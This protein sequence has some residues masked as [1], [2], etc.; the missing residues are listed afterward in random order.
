MSK[1]LQALKNLSSRT[2]PSETKEK[3][4][5][6]AAREAAA[7]VAVAPVAA[8]PAAAAADPVLPPLNR[9]QRMKQVLARHLAAPTP[10]E[11]IRRPTTEDEPQ[12]ATDFPSLQPT[13]AAA[14][15]MTVPM[16]A[17]LVELRRAAELPRLD[18]PLEPPTK[19]EPA[20]PAPSPI[21]AT[22]S[23]E[24][25]SPP[26][27]REALPVGIA[28]LEAVT[29]LVSKL[30][31]VGGARSEVGDTR[32]E[33]RGQRA[34][35][36]EQKSESRDQKAEV[37]DQKSALDVEAVRALPLVPS[38]L[39]PLAP[40]PAIALAPSLVAPAAAPPAPSPLDHLADPRPRVSSEVSEEQSPPPVPLVLPPRMISRVKTPLEERVLDFQT[41]PSRSLPYRELADRLRQDLRLLAGRCLL[42]AGVGPAS[43]A[44]D[45][46]P[47][48]A[49]LLA[50]DNAEV[51]LVD[52]DFARAAMTVGFGAMK[53]TGLG[54]LADAGSRGEEL[55]LPT[56]LPNVSLL[57]AGRKALPDN[58]G[59]V[60]RVAQ[61]LAKL[62]ERFSLVMVDGGMHTGPLLP[63]LARL[64][65]ATYLVVRLGA[66]DAR[67]ATAALK[68]IRATGARV[69]GCVATSAA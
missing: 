31:E 20:P 63:A 1:M 46:M 30:E 34:E 19:P 41:D 64:C 68:T 11:I 37:G 42:F 53:E 5:T 27:A 29:H 59:V 50:E 3:P 6:P 35:V 48:V 69:M 45:V 13:P 25:E 9:T 56:R 49:S 7:P 36:R 14:G 67:A 51:L 12:P 65:D 32:S 24:L 52:A 23:A 21:A 40:S 66:T 39:R 55:L 60:D 58:L 16:D 18:L 4:A 8:E 2:T 54:D 44:D 28:A 38:P 33:S 61:L 17:A 26:P 43:H 57:P 62:E 10:T 15:N 22:P 47:H